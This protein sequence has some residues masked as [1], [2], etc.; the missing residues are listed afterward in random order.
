[1][2]SYRNGYRVAKLEEKRK[3]IK[4]TNTFLPPNLRSDEPSLSPAIQR[5]E[6]SRVALLSGILLRDSS[7]P[8]DATEIPAMRAL[9]C[10]LH[11]KPKFERLH[12]DDVTLFW[13]A[14]KEKIGVQEGVDAA[15]DLGRKSV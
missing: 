15:R 13:S 10:D 4:E 2:P 5:S 9:D 8:Q 11:D 12:T 3:E 6:I 14:G 1:M 7:I